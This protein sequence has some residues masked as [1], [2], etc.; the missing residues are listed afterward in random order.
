MNRGSNSESLQLFGLDIGDSNKLEAQLSKI[1]KAVQRFQERVNSLEKK[2]GLLGAKKGNNKELQ[3]IEYEIDRLTKKY[4]GFQSLVESQKKAS[5]KKP[6]QEAAADRINTSAIEKKFDELEVR[7]SD[8]GKKMGQ[9]VSSSLNSIPNLDG[10]EKFVVTLKELFEIVEKI[11][12]SPASLSS[13]MPESDVSNITNEL[14]EQVSLRKEIIELEDGVAS[15]AETTNTKSV[16][17]YSQRA[18]SLKQ[19]IELEQKIADTYSNPNRKDALQEQE[20]LTKEAENLREELSK[21]N[22]EGLIQLSKR[23]SDINTKN[24]LKQAANYI[25]NAQTE[26]EKAANNAYFQK[27]AGLLVTIQRQKDELKKLGAEMRQ[28]NNPVLVEIMQQ[29]YEELNNTIEQNSRSLQEQR[30]AMGKSNVESLRHAGEMSTK[31]STILN[32]FGFGEEALEK[33]AN[34]FHEMGDLSA[35]SAKSLREAQMDVKRFTSIV[36]V[37][38]GSI[39]NLTQQVS[40][41]QDTALQAS[42]TIGAYGKRMESVGGI[43]GKF[44]GIVG[45]IGKTITTILPLVQR[46][47]AAFAG[48]QAAF[49]ISD[50]FD[51]PARI[52]NAVLGEENEVV[53]RSSAAIEKRI[54][55]IREDVENTKKLNDLIREGSVEKIRTEQMRIQQ[56]IDDLEFERQMLLDSA[57]MNTS[58]WDQLQ[59]VGSYALAEVTNEFFG[60]TKIFGQTGDAVS[61]IDPELRRLNRELERFSD[62]SLTAATRAF[63][64]LNAIRSGAESV[65]N[66]Y[67]D[68]Q[69]ELIRLRYD[70]IK[71]ENEYRDALIKAQTEYDNETRDVATQRATEDRNI[72]IKHADEMRIAEEKYNSDLETMRKDHL[73]ELRDIEV[74]YLG[75]VNSAVDKYQKE[76]QKTITDFHESEAKERATR[77]KEIIDDREEHVKSL[78]KIEADYQEQRLDKLKD[79]AND[80]FE[81]EMDNDAL[82]FFNTRR[83][84]EKT[85]AED[86]ANH[87]E[88]LSE[89]KKQFA[90]SQKEKSEAYAL[91]RAESRKQFEE[92]RAELEKE[93]SENL[94]MLKDE[95]ETEKRLQQTQF[96]EKMRLE[97]ENFIREQAERAEQFDQA[98]KERDIERKREDNDRLNRLAGRREELEESYNLELQYFQQR[99]DLLVEFLDDVG[100]LLQRR[101]D[102]M[103]VLEDEKLSTPQELGSAGSALGVEIG[104]I[105]RMMAERELTRAEERYYNDLTR[106]ME[107]INTARQSGSVLELSATQIQM[108][109]DAIRSPLDQA[110]SA[111]STQYTNRLEYD[112]K[113][114]MRTGGGSQAFERASSMRE[115]QRYFNEFVAGQ[116]NMYDQ[117]GL[118]QTRSGIQS[119]EEY[120]SAQENQRAIARTENQATTQELQRGVRNMNS[121]F[122]SGWE[123]IN[124]TNQRSLDENLTMLE[125][126]YYGERNIVQDSMSNITGSTRSAYNEREGITERSLENANRSEIRSYTTRQRRLERY[127]TD[128]LGQHDEYHDLALESTEDF[129]DEFGNTFSGG[130][131]QTER[132]ITGITNSMLTQMTNVWIGGLTTFV[133]STSRAVQNLNQISASAASANKFSQAT[134]GWT[135]TA[136]TKSQQYALNLQGRST[137]T[138]SSNVG[139]SAGVTV[140][141]SR[142]M[143]TSGLLAAKGAFVNKPT[144]LI[145]GEGERP[146]VVFPFD[147]SKGI[148]DDILYKMGRGFMDGMSKKSGNIQERIP[149]SR[150]EAALNNIGK[151]AFDIRNTFGNITIGG[152][153]SRGEVE[154]KFDAMMYAIIDVIYKATNPN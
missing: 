76:L 140:L 48:I 9:G 10:I 103:S 38:F 131:R 94:K 54:G 129:I 90:E 35:G 67:N 126:R 8:F 55:V 31:F 12:D 50:N 91:E 96:Q 72:L 37:Q 110:L 100:G 40:G 24:P 127:L 61:E 75:E 39:S 49:A 146:E 97:R 62:S 29:K 66:E 19:L 98:Q 152:D 63:A 68:R 144:A 151:R 18:S 106:L 2:K 78:E 132:T 81:A 41:F 99:E 65:E 13:L 93:H 123:E 148:P 102:A 82:R 5:T 154:Q 28:S 22:S 137:S 73:F 111:R 92:R 124:T 45:G 134:T 107:E 121:Y 47:T 3:K 150:S 64:E 51:A 149:I 138:P 26:M 86:E 79:Y 130:Y 135:G 27:Q 142:T 44:G 133:S 74:K 143:S 43:V 11:S 105:E 115:N 7:A 145:A 58:Y 16:K 88:E 114:E 36:A 109:T 136:L 104:R 84:M 21:V 33:A 153:L 120:R 25:T 89:E 46:F 23:F 119:I 32:K 52:R 15:K 14:T 139:S 116:Q 6:A 60:A 125:G 128:E 101:R 71:A 112:T 87:K 113:E 147:E 20:K 4:K 122:T 57:A 80:L 95:Y 34:S 69:E 83:E 42:S 70:T 141:S 53:N 108:L 1:E 77:E 30:E 118:I 56:E 59:T 85:L 17:N 117:M